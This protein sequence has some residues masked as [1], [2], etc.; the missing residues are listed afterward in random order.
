MKLFFVFTK[1]K[2]LFREPDTLPTFVPCCLPF[3]EQLLPTEPVLI[4]KRVE[5]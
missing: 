4:L 5:S 3:W 2:L 1:M